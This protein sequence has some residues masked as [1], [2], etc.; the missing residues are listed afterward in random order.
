MT[1]LYGSLLYSK[2][3][4]WFEELPSR[5]DKPAVLPNINSNVTEWK[6]KSFRLLFNLH[7]SCSA[8]LSISSTEGT[9]RSVSAPPSGSTSSPASVCVTNW[10]DMKSNSAGWQITCR[11]IYITLIPTL[12]PTALGNIENALEWHPQPESLQGSRTNTFLPILPNS[13]GKD[14]PNSG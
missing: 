3:L 2:W 10:G 14:S 5:T 6:K 8:S 13:H 7:A 9:G 1:R 11:Y 4:L 12:P